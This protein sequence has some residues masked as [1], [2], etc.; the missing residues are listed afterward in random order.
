[1]AFN[2]LALDNKRKALSVKHMYFNRYLWIRYITALFF[3][4]NLYLLLYLIVSDSNH[5][6][7]FLPVSLLLLQIIT[8]IEQ[9]AIY[10]NYDK[11]AKW[12]KRFFEVQIAAN[13][14]LAFIFFTPMQALFFA[15]LTVN[16]NGEILVLAFLLSGI[17]LAFLVI[18]HLHII[19]AQKDR[20]FFR[21]RQYEQLISKGRR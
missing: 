20:Q 15:K 2:K 16:S 1:M 19:S 9:F 13:L 6:L 4:L 12:T 5:Y 3:F 21:A 17:M 11:Q 7:Y 18:K 14:L 8:L 10:H